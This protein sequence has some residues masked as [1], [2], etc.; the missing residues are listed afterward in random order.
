M[1][2]TNQK[3]GAAFGDLL[4]PSRLAEMIPSAD[5]DASLRGIQ[6]SDL[7]ILMFM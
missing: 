3:A 5:F 2:E 6:F 7:R 1:I 4:K